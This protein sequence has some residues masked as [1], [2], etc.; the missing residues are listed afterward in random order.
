[1]KPRNILKVLLSLSLLTACKERDPRFKNADAIA[2]TGE[3]AAQP[4]P[5][6]ADY[7]KEATKDHSLPPYIRESAAIFGQVLRGGAVDEKSYAKAFREMATTRNEKTCRIWISMLLASE[8]GL[9]DVLNFSEVERVE[10]QAI[11]RNFDGLESNPLRFLRVL[12]SCTRKLT[13][14]DMP[15][16]DR[17][18]DSFLERFEKK[19]GN[20]EVGKIL[21]DSYKLEIKQAKEARQAGTVSW[22]I[23]RKN[24][25]LGE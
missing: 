11:Q 12:N 15:E 10:K 4:N 14:F 3:A 24:A 8:A 19:H 23:G 1:M 21:L 9:P 13:E 18:I 16:A 17:E 6:N 2:A 7:I 20:S 22:K 25:E 5:V